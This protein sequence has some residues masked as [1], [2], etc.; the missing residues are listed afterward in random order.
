MYMFIDS[1]MAVSQTHLLPQHAESRQHST[2]VKIFFILFSPCSS[3]GHF[4]RCI[5][6]S[7]F[8]SKTKF[9]TFGFR[10]TFGE[11]DLD[12]CAP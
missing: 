8:V 1:L 6:I 11:T 3:A 10:V 4:D 7:F 2:E 5:T 9:I 12:V